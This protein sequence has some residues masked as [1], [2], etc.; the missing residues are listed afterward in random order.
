MDKT[1]GNIYEKVVLNYHFNN[2][3]YSHIS[4]KAHAGRAD[5]VTF[6]LGYKINIKYY[7]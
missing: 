5:Y 6:G 7:L 3:W 4:L 2:K 1:D